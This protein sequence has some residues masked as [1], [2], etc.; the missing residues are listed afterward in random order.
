VP[1][2]QFTLIALLANRDTPAVVLIDASVKLTVQRDTAR[3]DFDT[4]GF[5]CTTAGVTVM[6]LAADVMYPA[7]K[8]AVT[9]NVTVD[10]PTAM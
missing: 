4:D 6:D 7:P 10:V 9:V 1:S 8:S 5:V 2:P 3:P